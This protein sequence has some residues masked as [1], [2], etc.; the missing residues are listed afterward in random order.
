VLSS[1]GKCRLSVS[2]AGYLLVLVVGW[3]LSDGLVLATEPP[4]A[5]HID[6]DFRS[7]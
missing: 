5:F 3:N 4:P 6:Q 1:E 7:I 2:L